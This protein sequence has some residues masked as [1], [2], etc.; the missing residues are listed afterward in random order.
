M[1]RKHT[2]EDLEAILDIWYKSSSIPH[3]FL[4]VSYVEKVKGD[5]RTL[6]VP[7]SETGVY[8][9]EDSVLDFVSM[10]GNE[11]AGLFVLPDNQ[12]K[13]IGSKLLDFVSESNENLEVEVF[14]K[15]E[16]GRAFY[17]KY[18]F[19]LISQFFHE[20]SNNEVLR[21]AYTCKS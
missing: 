21:L 11:I 19:K 8:E 13:G 16:I 3:H 15:N 17:Q 18:G 5:M 1:I 2:P 14:E 10:M 12:S 9:K 7:N 20:E 6:Y 4:E